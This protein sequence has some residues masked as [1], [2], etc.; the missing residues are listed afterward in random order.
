MTDH[1]DRP[2]LD[3]AAWAERHR[4]WRIDRVA[5]ALDRLPERREQFSTMG[6]LP[7]ERLYGPWDL[8][9]RADG[10][11][12]G[13]GGP[14]AVDHHGTPLRDGD[15]PYASFDAA[16]DIGLP[17]DPPFTR[18]VHPTGYRSRPWTMRMFAGFGSAEDT[19]ARFRQL[20]AAGQTGLSI[21]YDMPTLYGFDTDDE[22][23]E[24]EFGT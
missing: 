17:G 9:A 8:E 23:A 18:G 19:N 14:T 16:R 2:D 7:V 6:D 15:G 24:G 20:L 22:E 21:A 3:A 5:P 4:R 13:P 11:A 10:G 12:A 1:P